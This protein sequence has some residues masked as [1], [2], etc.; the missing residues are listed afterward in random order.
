MLAMYCLWMT[1]KGKQAQRVKKKK[2]DLS[3]IKI[4]EI[5]FFQQIGG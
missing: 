3:W 2:E 5:F 4:G 1:N